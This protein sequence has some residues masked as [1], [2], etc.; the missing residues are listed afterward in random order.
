MLVKGEEMLFALL[1]ASLHGRPADEKFF[2]GAS[3]SDWKVCYNTAVK[4]GVLALAWDGVVTLKQELHPPKALK[5]QWGISVDKYE[6]KHR[7]YCK[8]AEQLQKFY[9]EHNIVA[10]QMKGVG[11]SANYNVPSHREGGDID[12]F[13]YSADPEKLSHKQAN[14][15][16]DSLMTDKGIDVDFSHSYKHSNFFYEGI[17]I[18]N[19]RCIVNIE[20][21]PKFLGHLNDVLIK[22]M[23]PY[24]VKLYDGEFE[25][26]VPSPQFNMLFISCHAF[27]HYGSGIAL[28]HLYDWAA[29]VTRH[30]LSLPPEIVEKSY[31]RAIAAF[32]HLSNK[33]LGT[34]VD[35]SNMPGDYE[36]LADEML[37]EMLYPKFVSY[38]PYNN[39]IRIFFYKLGRVTRNAKLSK[40]VLGAPITRTI[41]KSLVSHLRVPSKI[42]N[43]GKE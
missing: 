37:E 28:H 29:L 18:E 22:Y 8:T 13:T 26:L 4:Q 7:R 31:L 3:G 17:S 41:Y 20:T 1:R 39:P 21:N 5:F 40:N 27:Q 15:L 16:A 33:Y 12:I 11:F 14:E 9:Q 25:I 23:D 30:G 34:K 10:V 32:S 38:V 19:H 36:S 2:K 43:R 35:L 6:S 24:K 42:L